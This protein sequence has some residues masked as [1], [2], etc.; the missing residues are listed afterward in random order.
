MHIYNRLFGRNPHT[1][2]LVA[3]LGLKD[4]W[5]LDAV[6][7][8]STSISFSLNEDPLK[9][10]RQKAQRII[11]GDLQSTITLVFTVS[12]SIIT[13]LEGSKYF[14][15]YAMDMMDS[16][17]GYA[18]FRV[19]FWARH[20]LAPFAT[21]LPI[22]L[23]ER[24]PALCTEA[25]KNKKKKAVDPTSRYLIASAVDLGR[26]LDHLMTTQKGSKESQISTSSTQTQPET[27][28]SAPQ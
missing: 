5:I 16:S 18:Q 24:F 1:D 19:P 14:L 27:A 2:I 23:D 22:R 4:K 20:A 21:D 26:V 15:G 17:V 11:L 8:K 28:V 25:R 7:R 9:A 3:M 13:T 6:I 12:E 10:I